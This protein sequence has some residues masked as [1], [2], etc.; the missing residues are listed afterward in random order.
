M[1][2]AETQAA[3]REPLLQ[4]LHISDLH[5]VHGSTE[6]W[7]DW[8]EMPW[9][10]L[11]QAHYSLPDPAGGLREKRRALRAEL[12]QFMMDGVSG[13]DPRTAKAF[14]RFLESAQLRAGEWEGKPLWIVQSGDLTTF[15][16]D[17]SLQAGRRYVERLRRSADA[18]VSLH[19]NHDVWPG[20]LPYCD[21]GS[22]DE[23]EARNLAVFSADAPDLPL[24]VDI[25]GT[26][27]RLEL[28]VLNTVYSD[29]VDNTLAV[30]RV[31]DPDLDALVEAL[32]PENSPD[33]PPRFRVLATHHPIH[34]PDPGTFKRSIFDEA[35]VSGRLARGGRGLVELILSGHTHALF[36][37]LGLLPDHASDAAQRHLAAGQ[38]QMVVGT[39]LQKDEFEARNPY[40]HQGQLLRFWSSELPSGRPRI[41]VER[42]MLARR[43]RRG[44]LGDFKMIRADASR[45]AIQA[46]RFDL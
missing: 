21:P 34:N 26:D 29:Y 1:T 19:G 3:G 10:R 6:P 38:V 39:L 37:G 2:S 25:P 44:G 40:P 42:T 4:L 7:P 11:V 35:G 30:G 45:T 27:G 14:R 43:G 31:M 20:Q 24:C 16:D 18:V 46:L 9:S 32:G 15:G 33:A 8:N 17:A 41:T 22:I 12:Y 5:W 28:H 23:Y 13:H 36:P